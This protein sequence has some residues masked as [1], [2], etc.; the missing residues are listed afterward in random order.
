M[1]TIHAKIIGDSALVPRTDLERLVQLAKQS[2]QINL[3]IQED[4]VPTLGL[5]RL[6]EEGGAF[7]FWRE[8]GEDVYSA[9]DGEPV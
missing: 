9:D 6:I 4:D 3:E 7:D 2:E 1:T 5:M 8:E